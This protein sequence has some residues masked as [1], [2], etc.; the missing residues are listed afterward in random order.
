MRPVP[1]GGRSLKYPTEQGPTDR[2]G[3]RR[4]GRRGAHLRRQARRHAD[5]LGRRVDNPVDLRPGTASSVGAAPPATRCPWTAGPVARRPAAPDHRRWDLCQPRTRSPWHRRRLQSARLSPTPASP[6]RI[7]LPVVHAGRVQV[8]TVLPRVTAAAALNGTRTNVSQSTS[9]RMPVS[10]SVRLSKQDSFV[11]MAVDSTQ[12]CM[13]LC[14]AFRIQPRFLVRGYDVDTAVLRR[15]VLG[16]R[17]LPPAVGAQVG[18]HGGELPTGPRSGGLGGA[19][20]VVGRP[21]DHT[22]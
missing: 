7:R 16:G 19:R 9:S 18:Q 21:G 6:A 17:R 12:G 22:G 14:Q 2:T 4:P 15:H 13:L 3:R 10:S 20:G 5:R 1:P 11:A 8:P